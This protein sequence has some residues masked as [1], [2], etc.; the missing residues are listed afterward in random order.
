MIQPVYARHHR[1]QE[2]EQVRTGQ[3][4][5]VL[6]YTGTLALNLNGPV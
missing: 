3:I 1:H 6:L 4:V 5:L 2:D